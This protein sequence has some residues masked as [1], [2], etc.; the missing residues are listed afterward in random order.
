MKDAEIFPFNSTKTISESRRGGPADIVTA[1]ITAS[2]TSPIAYLMAV[3][4][5][6]WITA[7]AVDQ[8][9]SVWQRARGS[10]GVN[11]VAAN[12]DEGNPDQDLEM[13]DIPPH[14]CAYGVDDVQGMNF[15]TDDDIYQMV[16]HSVDQIT[17]NNLGIAS[18]DLTDHSAWHAVYGHLA[19]TCTPAEVHKE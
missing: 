10:P 5:S 19:W 14:T 11:T 18:W 15:L 3:P 6:L 4:I 8:W 1:T 12:E 16:Y 7:R 13:G 17:G 9:V 2:S